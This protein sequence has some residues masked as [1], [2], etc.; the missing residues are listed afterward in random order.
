MYLMLNLLNLLN[1]KFKVFQGE[2]EQWN[3]ATYCE[4]I[5]FYWQVFNVEIQYDSSQWDSMSDQHVFCDVAFTSL[6]WIHVAR[7]LADLATGWSQF[8]ELGSRTQDSPLGKKRKKTVEE[9]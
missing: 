8:S 6:M 4:K 9:F 5:S 1:F 2:R 3:I 7:L